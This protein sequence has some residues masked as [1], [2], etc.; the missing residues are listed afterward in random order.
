MIPFLKIKFYSMLRLFRQ[1]MIS[2]FGHC[3]LFRLFGFLIFNFLG[4]IGVA[5][6]SFGL[7]MVPNP[8]LKLPLILQFLEDTNPLANVLP[9][10][11]LWFYSFWL[12]HCLPRWPCLILIF[13][14]LFPSRDFSFF[15]LLPSDGQG[16]HIYR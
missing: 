4:W 8:P 14:L 15:L 12:P 2:D 11:L 13:E 16:Y 7:G 9:P 6:F 1:G 5:K 3:S 10:S